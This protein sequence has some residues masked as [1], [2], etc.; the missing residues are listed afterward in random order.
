M[1]EARTSNGAY[2][3]TELFRCLKPVLEQ[4]SHGYK[5]ALVQ[6]YL[7]QL[8]GTVQKG[9]DEV[10]R[11]TE[12]LVSYLFDKSLSYSVCGIQPSDMYPYCYIFLV[13]NGDNATTN[14][15][16]HFIDAISKLEFQKGVAK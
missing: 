3:R 6:F 10:V 8:D 16:S 11:N 12:S 9:Y 5:A 4:F 7:C 14:I 2:T 15:D 13:E 1:D